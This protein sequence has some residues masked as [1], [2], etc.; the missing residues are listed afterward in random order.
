M[1][2]KKSLTIN[3]LC[4][5]FFQGLIG[6]SSPYSSRAIYYP[7]S[8]YIFYFLALLIIFQWYRLDSDSVKYKRSIGMNIG[9]L[10]LPALALPYYFYDSRGFIQGTKFTIL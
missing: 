8:D 2:S 4:I 7:N 5:W 1:K 3:I 9:I 10:L 6:A